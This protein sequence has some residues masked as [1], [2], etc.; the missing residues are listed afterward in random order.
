MLLGPSSWHWCPGGSGP[1]SR[2][3]TERGL[4]R[5]H[6]VCHPPWEHALEAAGPGRVAVQR[7]FHHFALG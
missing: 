5:P 4:A 7:G 3:R 2:A 6:A 1:R